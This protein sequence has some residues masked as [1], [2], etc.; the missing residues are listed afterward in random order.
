MSDP[1]SN[2]LA[3]IKN[4][5]AVHHPTVDI[6]FSK[7]KYEITKILEK[8][9]FI[10][11]AEKKGRKINKTIEITL[12]YIDNIPAI[13]GLKKISKPGQRIYLPAKKIKRVQGGYG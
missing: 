9:K 8:E 3:I 12:K 13:S 7:L 2:M 11:G 1:V 10:T 5:Q 4:A 6:P